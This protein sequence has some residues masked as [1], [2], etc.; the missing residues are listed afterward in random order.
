MSKLELQNRFENIRNGFEG[1]IEFDVP[2][3]RVSYYK[4]GGPVSVLVTPKSVSDLSRISLILHETRCRYFIL[5]WGSNLLFSDAGFDGVMIR[6]KSVFTEIIEEPGQLLQVGSSVGAPSLLRK[7]QE[8]GYGSL[9]R[10]TGI[11]GSVGGMITMNAGTHL[12]AMDSLVERVETLDL[13]NFTSP[14]IFRVIPI[15]PGFFSYR[16]NSFLKTHELITRVWLRYEPESSESVTREIDTLYQ[17]R[18]ASQ[19]VDYPSCGSVFMNPKGRSGEQG[20]GWNAWQVVDRLGL[21]GHRI[22]NAQI[23]EKHSNFIINLG[24]AKADDVKALI[25]LVQNRAQSELGIDLETEV[26]IID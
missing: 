16:K 3:S 9:S 15:K 17:R 14:F 20:E 2:L 7:A 6:M 4:I 23:S 18:K 13:L 12:G 5:G 25:E 1:Q 8:K 10:L 19:P 24:G 26:R 21:R 11:P 22:G